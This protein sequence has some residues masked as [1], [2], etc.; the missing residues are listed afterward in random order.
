MKKDIEIPISKGVH[1]VAIQQWNDDFQENSWYAY[2]INENDQKLEMALV[3]SKAYG[4]ID[5]ESRE[6]AI[7]RHA[8]KEVPAKEAVKIELLEN[9]ILQLTNEFRLTYFLENKMYEKTF[10]FRKNTINERALQPL[11]IIKQKGILVK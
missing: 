5:G 9:N 4:T 6:S 2:L 8:F 3:V 11:P 7:F 1:I 10:V